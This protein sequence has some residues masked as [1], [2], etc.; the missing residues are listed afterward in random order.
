MPAN[1]PVGLYTTT[2]VEFGKSLGRVYLEFRC[3]QE[4]VER[5]N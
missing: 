1:M 5:P 2:V 3:L 4:T